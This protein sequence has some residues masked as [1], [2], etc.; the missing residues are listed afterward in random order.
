M[1]RS[2]A[3]PEPT[4]NWVPW[5]LA[6]LAVL[7]FATGASYLYKH[8]MLGTRTVPDSLPVTVP[9]ESV[10]S[11]VPD[12]TAIPDSVLM[13]ELSQFDSAPAVEP[14]P[15]KP[16][17]PVSVPR[18]AADAS[19]GESGMLQLAN[20]PP[21]SQVF[22]DAKPVTQPGGGIR[23]STGWHELGVS[24]P[25][26]LFFTDSVKVESGKTLVVTPTLSATNAP[27][28]PPG[29]RAELRRRALAR[30]DCDHPS[31]A[32]RFG[33]MCYDNRPMPIGPTRVPVPDGVTGVPSDVVLVV[34]VSRQGRTLAVLTK[35]PSNE[36][37]FT[38]AV[39]DHAQTLRW[40]PAI[41]EGQPVD[42]WTQA[43][44]FPDTP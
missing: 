22:V 7:G 4:N 39:E 23:V 15:S 14:K 13:R 2:V 19:N 29:S 38:K 41:L 34:K 43:A 35:T 1:R 16:A 42:G 9:P 27:V 44:F 26:F 17:P 31:A 3:A 30:L 21:R 37:A 6:L 32:N 25:G 11:A 28:L 18:R 5:L 8:G 20:L 40:T 24:A 33:A 36:P 12:S 10:Q